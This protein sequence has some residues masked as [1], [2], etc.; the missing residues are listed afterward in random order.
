MSSRDLDELARRLYGRISSQLRA[1]LRRDRD[2]AGRV[3]NL[4]F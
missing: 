1:E 2:R 3:S 4:D